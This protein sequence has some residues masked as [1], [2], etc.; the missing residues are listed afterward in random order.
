M[1]QIEKAVAF[2]LDP[3]AESNLKAQAMSFCEQ[4]KSAPDGWQLCLT[5]FVRSPKSTPE[6]R[7][8]ALQVLDDVLQNRITSLNATEILYI[9][10]TLMDFV[11]R[12]YVIGDG[13]DGECSSEP[14]YLKNKFAHTLTLLF[15]QIY[16]TSWREFF[17]EFLGLL[18]SNSHVRQTNVRTVDLFLRIL[19]SIDEEVA[20][21]VVPRGKEE[22]NRNTEI[23]DMMRTGDVQ[24][25]TSTLYDILID[26]RLQDQDIVQMC[27]KIIG[28]YIAWIDVSLIVNEAYMNLIYQFFGNPRLR[29]SA[30]ECLTEHTNSFHGN[31]DCIQR[32]E[33]AR[34][35]ESDSILKFDGYNGKTDDIDFVEQ[36]AKLTNTLGTELCKIW[37]ET[38]FSPEAR[39]AAYVQIE[40][41]LPFLLKFL[42]D[43][44][45]ETSSAVFS[46]LKKQKK[47]NGE[48]SNSQREFLASLLNVIVMKMRYDD[49]TD[50]GGAD[51]EEVEAEFLEMR[52]AGFIDAIWKVDEP[53]F[54]TYI[55]SAVINT[56]DNYQIR[57]NEIGWREFELALH[58]LYLYGEAYQGQPNFL[59][60]QNNKV[61]GLSPLGE[62]VQKM[63]E[64]NISAYP[65]PSIPLSFFE[66]VTRYYQFFEM[67]SDHIPIVLQTFVDTR[68]LHHPSKQIRSRSWYL[69]HRFVRSLKPYMNGY[70]GTVLPLIQDLLII[71]AEI[72]PT[73]NA[74]ESVLS[75]DQAMSGFFSDQIYLFEVVGILITVD[76]IPPETQLKFTEEIINPLLAEIQLN[77]AIDPSDPK[78]LFSVLQLHHLMMAIAS[79]GKGFPDASKPQATAA[80]WIGIFKQATQ[81]VL[82][83]LKSLDR[84]EIIRDAARFSFARFVNVLG[85]EI[86]P[87]IPP[88]ING[89]LNESQVSELVDFLPFIG[90]IAH[91]FKPKIFDIL[92]ELILP[93]VNKVFLF[94]NQ[95]PSGTD[96][97]LLLMELRKAYISFIL[98]LF[99][100]GMEAVFIS[101]LNRPHLESILQS[102]VHYA[103][104]AS[105]SP[106]LRSSFSILSKAI[107]SW[108][109]TPKTSD[110]TDGMQSNGVSRHLPGFDRFMYEQILRICFE[111]P[112][113]DT[114]NLSDGQSILVL[115]EICLIMKA[116]LAQQGSDFVDYLRGTWLPSIQCPPE[117]AEEFLQVLQQLDAKALRKYFQEFI[118]KLKS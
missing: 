116:M 117:L 87:Y 6:A 81:A 92:N 25:L 97:A 114:F 90:L 66:N 24:K 50:W 70:A 26:Y 55:H 88:L 82:Y 94:L 19:L 56:L 65:H 42:G 91:K 105:D 95:A 112:L 53:L 102:V 54:T 20:S 21:L 38:E 106:L 16:T 84:F 7:I 58:L 57:G 85:T 9:K 98:G 52:K 10:N 44:Y 74:G 40:L 104:D 110:G 34:K 67:Q 64:S 76:S 96:E 115:N 23:K 103:S 111:V 71:Q 8:F 101:E 2:A 63:I 31:S 109:G 86:L 48:L 41:L 27:L 22:N 75:K 72:P 5:L 47:K 100:Y 1:E 69:F 4:V 118:R 77:L 14:N 36:V 108:G 37:D 33:T 80:P 35:A 93:L 45:D 89:L 79:I 30:C 13:N 39:N 49:E 43:E 107:A 60:K 18:H 3:S 99:N 59:V 32:Y 11:K 62:M 73:I 28:L 68:G 78:Y 46:F 61:V 15:V 17:N 51:E 12:E 83:V 29:I 113:R